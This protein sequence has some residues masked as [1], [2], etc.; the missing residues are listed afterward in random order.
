MLIS[1][2][3]LK[4]AVSVLRFD[5]SRISETGGLGILILKPGFQKLAKILASIAEVHLKLTRECGVPIVYGIK[6]RTGFYAVEM[7]VSNGYAMPKLTLI[8]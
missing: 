4:E 5:A 2:Y 6:P 1:A 7:D 8:I 3:G